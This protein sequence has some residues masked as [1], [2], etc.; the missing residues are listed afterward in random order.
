MSYL[1]ASDILPLRRLQTS[2]IDNHKSLSW[3]GNNSLRDYGDTA[4]NFMSESNRLHDKMEGWV[5][6]L[7][8]LDEEATFFEFL[9]RAMTREQ[10]CWELAPMS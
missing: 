3:D 4:C 10:V 8:S 6:E 9:S 5:A 2:I 7:R 1:D